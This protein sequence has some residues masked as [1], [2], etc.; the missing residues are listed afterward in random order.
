L[1]QGGAVQSRLLVVSGW[2]REVLSIMMFVGDETANPSLLFDF[3]LWEYY[4]S[5]VGG[6][7]MLT[8]TS[9]HAEHSP[10]PE[11]GEGAIAG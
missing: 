5:A 3:W 11:S 7:S 1:I 9:L 8:S 6:A 10:H 4:F 2:F